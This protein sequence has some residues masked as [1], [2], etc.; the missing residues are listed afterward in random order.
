MSPEETR[1]IHTRIWRR[2][3]R[4]A[5]RNTRLRLTGEEVEVLGRTDFAEDTC[6]ANDDDGTPPI[7]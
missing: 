4:A 6:I 2:V 3:R 1:A 5:D 7:V